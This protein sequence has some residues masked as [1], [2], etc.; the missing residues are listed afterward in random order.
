MKKTLFFIAAIIW[1]ACSSDH[2]QEGNLQDKG[3]ILII[4]ATKGQA[5]TRGLS[6]SPDGNTLNAIWSEGDVV[7]VLSASGSVLGTL[8]PETTGSSSTTLKSTSPISVIK[9]DKLTLVFP[10]TDRDYTGQKGTLEDI[11]TKYDY[12]TA[13]VTVQDINGSSASTDNAHFLNQQAIVRFTLKVGSSVLKPTSLT[14]AA[15]GLLQKESTPGPI[16]ITPTPN[17]SEIYAALSGVDNKIVTLTATKGS[18]TYSYTTPETSPKTFAD[19]KFYSVTAK[20]TKEPIPYPQPLTLE[21][22]DDDGCTVTV[23]HYR[24]LEYYQSDIKEW[25]EYTS[26]SDIQLLKGE[27]VNFRGTNATQGAD[28]YMNITCSGKCYVYG[29][30]MSLLSKDNFAT[31]TNLPYDKTFQNLFLDN[32]NIFHINGKDLVLPATTLV[33]ECYYQMFSGCVNLSYIKCL[34]TDIPANNDCTTDWLKGA[35]TYIL[36]NG[37]TCTFVMAEGFEGI[38]EKKSASGIPDDWDIIEE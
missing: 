31:M 8:K 16:T 21:C 37:G 13:S 32:D 14:I 4:E 11:E 24:N 3:R 27:W 33:S 22:F 36:D 1:T 7:S 5:D 17:T 28:D 19:G 35:G 20:L 15:D 12:A 6:P 25:K 2:V 23:T 18:R 26:D 38:W 29:N 34:A 30:V 9:G 10:R